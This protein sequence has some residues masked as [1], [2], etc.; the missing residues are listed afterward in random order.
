MAEGNLS[1]GLNKNDP[2]HQCCDKKALHTYPDHS[3]RECTPDTKK[4]YWLTAEN[5]KNG[6]IFKVVIKKRQFIP[7]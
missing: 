1:Q 5:M 4:E 6:P 3:R 2:K 7:E